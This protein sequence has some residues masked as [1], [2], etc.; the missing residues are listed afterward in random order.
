MDVRGH[1]QLFLSV[2]A[3]KRSRPVVLVE[4]LSISPQ[5]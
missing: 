1:A 2:I 3:A 5:C 4:K